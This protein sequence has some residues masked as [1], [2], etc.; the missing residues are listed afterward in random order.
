M[1]PW[2]HPA[3]LE[4]KTQIGAI[5]MA[6]GATLFQRQT[7]TGQIGRW[8]YHWPGRMFG[9]QQQQA[10][11]RGEGT[12]WIRLRWTSDSLINRLIRKEPD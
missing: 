1:A 12:D 6:A 11:V 5:P 4:I 3:S 8:Q 7:V 10:A 9:G 2:H